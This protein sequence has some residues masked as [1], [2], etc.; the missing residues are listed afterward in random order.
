MTVGICGV[1][2]VTLTTHSIGRSGHCSRQESSKFAGVPP[3]LVLVVAVEEDNKRNDDRSSDDNDYGKAD[4]N[5]L[6][7]FSK[8]RCCKG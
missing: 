2:K 7:F 3:V 4:E 1:I 5:Y 8:R 6:D